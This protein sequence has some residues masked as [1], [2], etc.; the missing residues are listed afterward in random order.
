MGFVIQAT[1]SLLKN[2]RSMFFRQ[3]PACATQILQGSLRPIT[4]SHN[5]AL[6]DSLSVF[7]LRARLRGLSNRL[8]IDPEAE[9]MNNGIYKG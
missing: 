5:D 7:F 1:L 2:Q 8:M 4:K 9:V 6:E 3:C